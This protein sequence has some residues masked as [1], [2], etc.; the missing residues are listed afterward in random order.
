MLQQFSYFQRMIRGCTET[1]F[2]DI[3]RLYL[4]V[5]G[6]ENPEIINSKNDGGRDV[7]IPNRKDLN[8]Q[9]SIVEDWKSKIKKDAKKIIDDRQI[10]SKTLRY[11]TNRDIGD[12]AVAKFT[13]EFPYKGQCEFIIDDV[14]KITNQIINSNRI[15]ELCLLLGIPVTGKIKSTLPEKAI[16]VFLL[17]SD[18]S[19]EFKNKLIESMI[20]ASIYNNENCTEETILAIINDSKIFGDTPY[21]DFIKARIDYMIIKKE[22]IKNNN[23]ISLSLENLKQMEQAIIE[24]SVHKEHDIQ[25]IKNIGFSEEFATELLNINF[26]DY[27]EGRSA[28]QDNQLRTIYGNFFSLYKISDKELNDLINLL[29]SL[30]TLQRKMFEISLEKILGTNTFDIFRVLG[31]QTNI[32]VLLDANVAIPI[33]LGLSF[34]EYKNKFLLSSNALLDLCKNHDFKIIIPAVY[35]NEIAS[36]GYS[37]LEYVDQIKEYQKAGNIIAFKNSKNA[38]VNFYAYLLENND[39]FEYND[40]SCFLEVFGIKKDKRRKEIE[41]FI[42]STFENYLGD[43]GVDVDIPYYSSEY[44]EEYFELLEEYKENNNKILVE[45][46]AIVWTHLM[47]DIDNG[48]I[49]VTWEKEFMRNLIEKTEI[50]A[51]TPSRIRDFLLFTSNVGNVNDDENLINYEL[52][53]ELLYVLDDRM[54]HLSESITEQLISL[55][56]ENVRK[57]NEFIIKEKRK[58]IENSKSFENDLRIQISELPEENDIQKDVSEN[59]N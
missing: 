15:K 36:H 55:P 31:N 28:D 8:I 4:Q 47:N 17:Y 6:F 56:K 57:I 46:D 9:L 33:L 25:C 49:V 29:P 50:Y 11:I 32:N 27:I 37:A 5:C 38:F 53:E 20:K 34:N 13:E 44:D 1:Q 10:H 51:G 18:E 22:I 59:I 30:K 42:K 2:Y 12:A 43:L 26:K 14:K 3:A 24:I 19:I 41:Y 7:R 40:F 52:M 35:I 21:S 23:N 45:H 16:S 54:L 48:Y 39:S 58:G